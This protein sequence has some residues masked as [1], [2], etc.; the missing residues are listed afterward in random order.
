MSKLFQDKEYLKETQY[1]NS[2]NL[3]ARINLHKEYS[4]A[5]ED[6][7]PWVFNR[8]SIK[9]SQRILECGCGPGNLWRENLDRI[10]ENCHITLTDLSEGMVN[11]AK[12]ALKNSEHDFEFQPLNIENLPFDDYSFDTVIANHMLYHVPDIEQA[13]GEVM[14]VLKPNGRFVA[15]TNGDNHMRELSEIGLELF[16][17][18]EEL[19]D[20]RLTR[21]E[22]RLLGFRLSNGIDFL[23]ERFSQVELHLYE[24][25]LIVTESAPLVNYVLSNIGI[26]QNPPAGFVEKLT[27]YLDKQIAEK[28]HVYI[29]K[30]S[31]LFVAKM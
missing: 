2:T 19:K 20:T 29:T 16:A 24:S 22:N 26:D 6:W 8:L 25:S 12:S 3:G 15:A 13:I 5:K 7:Q 30:E 1:K 18:M 10:P 23:E 31:G 17:D 4:Q 21:L 28:G 14:R 27:A 11:E 9:M